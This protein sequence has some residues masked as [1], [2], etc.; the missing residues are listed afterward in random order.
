MDGIF[1]P[2]A[3]LGMHAPIVIQAWRENVSGLEPSPGKTLDR[4]GPTF[5]YRQRRRRP[6]PPTVTVAH[7]DC[8]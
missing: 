7:G 6:L 8:A 1:P 3:V 5:E 4:P 2:T